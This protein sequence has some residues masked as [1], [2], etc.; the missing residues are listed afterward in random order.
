MTPTCTTCPLYRDGF[1]PLLG[2]VVVNLDLA[3][4]CVAYVRESK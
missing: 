4:Y 1:C 2:I 3:R